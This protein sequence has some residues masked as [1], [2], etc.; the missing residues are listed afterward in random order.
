MEPLNIYDLL[1]VHRDWEIVQLPENSGVIIADY[2]TIERI[3]D[4]ASEEI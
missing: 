2:E 4:R 1:D 3:M